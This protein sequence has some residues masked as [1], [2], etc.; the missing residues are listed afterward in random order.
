MGLVGGQHARLQ[1]VLGGLHPLLFPQ[2]VAALR[3]EAMAVVLQGQR[4]A[5]RRRE[6]QAAQA[7]G[8]CPDTVLH[9]AHAPT[10]VQCGLLQPLRPLLV[11]VYQLCP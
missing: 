8:L 6:P 7:V 10:V 9:P 2:L 3:R 11:R 5:H 1:G 4:W